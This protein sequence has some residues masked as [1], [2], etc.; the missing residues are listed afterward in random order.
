M[1]KL[2][3]KRI[4]EKIGMDITAEAEEKFYNAIVDYIRR[5]THQSM[6]IC[7]YSGTKTLRKEDVELALEFYNFQ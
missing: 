4:I 1:S 2:L 3:K 7:R 6:E 5:I